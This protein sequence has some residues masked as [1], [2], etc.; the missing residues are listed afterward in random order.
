MKKLFIVVAMLLLVM[1]CGAEKDIA[2][3]PN[4]A[5]PTPAPTEVVESQVASVVEEEEEVPTEI[6]IPSS[7]KEESAEIDEEEPWLKGSCFDIDRSFMRKLYYHG[8]LVIA[9]EDDENLGKL[10]VLLPVEPVDI[11]TINEIEE[12]FHTAKVNMANSIMKHELPL[13]LIDVDYVHDSYLHKHAD[14]L[15]FAVA[16]AWGDPT[17][18]YKIE[19]F[20]SVFKKDGTGGCRRVEEDE[21]LGFFPRFICQIT[22]DYLYTGQSRSPYLDH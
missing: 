2:E 20:K 19:G 14:Y 3:A 21:A 4:V 5:A 11:C 22:E 13:K 16:G 6:V 18:E 1:G 17:V 12:G 7:E 8:Y 9:S 10:I 15:D